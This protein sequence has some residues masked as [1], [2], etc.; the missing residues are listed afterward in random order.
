MLKISFQAIE[1]V[2]KFEII[3]VLQVILNLTALWARGF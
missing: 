1:M 3:P 2:K